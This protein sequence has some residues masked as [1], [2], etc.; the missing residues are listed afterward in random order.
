M[1]GEKGGPFYQNPKTAQNRENETLTVN[2]M[3]I[4]NLKFMKICRALKSCT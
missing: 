1:I 2:F 4:R 3:Y